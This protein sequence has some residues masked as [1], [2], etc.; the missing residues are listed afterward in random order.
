M[1]QQQQKMFVSK[2]YNSHI[3]RPRQMTVLLFL[4]L[5]LLAVV[6][7]ERQTSTKFTRKQQNKNKSKSTVRNIN[8][9]YLNTSAEK[10]VK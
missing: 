6:R 10:T 5:L 7:G 1:S 3:V 8:K 4:S 2:V 9:L